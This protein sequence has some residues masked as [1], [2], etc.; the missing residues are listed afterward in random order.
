MNVFSQQQC[1][2]ISMHYLSFGSCMHSNSSFISSNIPRV[3]SRAWLTPRCWRS[4][5]ICS[6]PQRIRSGLILRLT[7][8]F[9]SVTDLLRRDQ[10]REL[11][12]NYNEVQT[13]AHCKTRGGKV[14]IIIQPFQLLNKM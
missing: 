6:S 10:H 11:G 13:R 9:P 12:Y 8:N 1:F 14:D 7:S 3:M 5:K 4:L 2:R